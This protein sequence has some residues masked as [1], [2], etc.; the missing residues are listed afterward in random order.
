MDTFIKTRVDTEAPEVSSRVPQDITVKV[1]QFVIDNLLFGQGAD[2]F[3]DEDSFL[4]K[5]LVDST[6]M[7]SLVEFVIETFGIS[8]DDGEIVPENW[9]SLNRIAAFVGAKLAE[10]VE[11]AEKTVSR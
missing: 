11:T 3:S 2:T 7:L 6:G 9:D 5:G 8:V 1:R 4:E 10:P